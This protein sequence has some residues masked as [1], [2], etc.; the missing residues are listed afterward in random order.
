MIYFNLNKENNDEKLLHVYSSDLKQE[1][2]DHYNAKPIFFE[3]Y[4]KGILL[5]KL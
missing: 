5:C 3:N 1:K 4:P 2:N